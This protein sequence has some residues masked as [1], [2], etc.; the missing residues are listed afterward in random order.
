V[1]SGFGVGYALI[2]LILP[3]VGLWWLRRERLKGGSANS[4]SK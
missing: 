2:P 1:W 3:I 4:V